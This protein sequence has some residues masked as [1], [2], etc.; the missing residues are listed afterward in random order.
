M[1]SVSWRCTV[2]GPARLTGPNTDLLLERKAAA[3]IAYLALEGATHRARLTLLLWPETRETAARNN[4]VQLLRKL[5][6]ATGAELIVGGELLSLAPAFAVDALEA[7]GLVTQGR[8]AEFAA[9]DPSL[10]AGLSYDDCPDLDDWVTAERERWLE[11]H[12][13]ALREQASAL[14]QRGDVEGAL[15]WAQRLLTT[16]PIS[17]DAWRRVMRLQY[18]RGDR[19]A[20]L[21]M[22]QRCQEVLARELGV[23]PLPETVALAR[24]IERGAVAVPERPVQAPPLATLRPPRLVGRAAEWARMEAAWARGQWVVIAGEPGVGKSRLALDFAA[25]KGAFVVFAG[26]PGDADQPQ[27]TNAR[28]LRALM[29]HQDLPL[30]PWVRRELARVLPELAPEGAPPAMTSEAD[31][32]RFRQAQRACFQAASGAVAAVIADDWQF[33]DSGSRR[34]GVFLFSSGGPLG[35]PGGLPRL[36]VTY[37][38]AELPDEAERAL[39]QLLAQDLAVLIEL[40]AVPDEGAQALLDDLGV[41]PDAGTRARLWRHAG[42]NPLFVLETVRLLHETGQ[43]ARGWPEQLPLPQK[44]RHLIGRRLSRLSA[45]AVQAARAA[46]VLQSDFDL[47]LVAEVLGAP[48]LDLAEAWEELEA[49]QVTQGARFTHDLVY[50]TVDGG[51]PASVRALLHRSAA[52]VLTRAG[53]RPARIARHWHEGGRTEEAAEQY[54]AAAADAQARYQMVETA[55][56]GALAAELFEAAGQPDRAFDALNQR[57]A[58]FDAHGHD[59]PTYRRELERLSALART[60]AQRGH[61]VVREAEALGASGDLEGMGRVAAGGLAFALEA[62]DTRLEA[63]MHEIMAVADLKLGRNASALPALRR[64]RE[65]GE[66]LAD[67]PVQALALQ[68]LGLVHAA[69][70]PR[71]ALEVYR[72]AAALGRGNDLRGRATMQH[73]VAHMLMLLGRVRASLDAYTQARAMLAGSTGLTDVH[74]LIVYGHA[75]CQLALGEYGGAWRDVLELQALDPQQLTPAAVTASIGHALALR[76]F[77]RADLAL[78]VLRAALSHPAFQVNLRARGLTLFGA[79]LADLGRLEEARATFEDAERE[80]GEEAPVAVFGEL[81]A[82]RAVVLDPAARL[83]DAGTLRELAVSL[84][85]SGLRDAALVREAEALVALGRPAALPPAPGEDGNVVFSP[86]ELHGARAAVIRA[87]G[88]DPTP[89]LVAARAWLERT[90]TALPEEFRAAFMQRHADLMNAPGRMPVGAVGPDARAEEAP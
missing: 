42:G 56:L 15:V 60:P 12:T 36:I 33:F 28:A 29:E 45:R 76:S 13:S 37:R 80:L 53:A 75:S 49:A 22:Y 83:R 46:A 81:L 17:E 61:L 14:E 51:T 73:R 74:V 10:L 90:C 84:G 34:D 72:A 7:R 47:E 67:V 87:D 78:E 88:G 59:L 77:G 50:E 9:L 8:T 86:A 39:H 26:R 32:L 64:L 69:S 82:R 19:P 63:R 43:L 25:S 68:G 5:R 30:E 41:P 2:L 85:L 27:A 31:L 23:E 11:W 20:A 44:V 16:D 3:L 70:N 54:A 38:R 65:I 18:V 24:E 48:L 1:T 57:L 89:E 52:R 35:E 40:G 79:I 21:R 55:Q 58:S 4:L 6:V 62:G 71:E 66:Q